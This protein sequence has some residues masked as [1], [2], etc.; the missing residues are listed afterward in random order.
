LK[1][2]IPTDRTSLGNPYKIVSDL[3]DTVIVFFLF[4]VSTLLQRSVVR[5]AE[6]GLKQ[7]KISSCSNPGNSIDTRKTI[8]RAKL[9]KKMY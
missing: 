1:K 5:L 8:E 4:F 7:F 3:V 9:K 6:V 2:G